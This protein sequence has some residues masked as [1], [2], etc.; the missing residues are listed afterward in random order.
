MTERITDDLIEWIDSHRWYCWDRVN[1]HRVDTSDDS[2]RDQLYDIARRID[3][4]HE[5]ALDAERRHVLVE[6]L[7]DGLSNEDLCEGR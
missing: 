3:K 6:E 2:I 1:N 4:A 5:K 7:A